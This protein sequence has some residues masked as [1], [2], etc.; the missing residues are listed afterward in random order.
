MDK[1][2]TMVECPDVDGLKCLIQQIKMPFMMTN[3]SVVTLYYTIEEAD[4]SLVFISSSRGTE[5]VAAGLTAVIDKNVL[6][7]NVVNYTKLT[8]T[9]TGCDWVSVQCMDIGG[10]I[11]AALKRQGASKMQ[12]VAMRMIHLIKTGDLPA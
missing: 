1:N 11:P 8:P 3:R 4:G 6:G 2:A 7:N 10:S 12:S 5:S 9:E